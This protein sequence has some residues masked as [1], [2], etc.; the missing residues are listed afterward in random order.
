ML[1]V[2]PEAISSNFPIFVHMDC[3]FKCNDDEFPILILG[4]TD[5]CQKFHPLSTSIISHQTEDMYEELMN[6]F[7]RLTPHVL[8]GVTFT[9]VYGMIDCGA[10]KRY[11]L[12]LCL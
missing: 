11:H 9:P 1:S 12:L 4:T 2:I 5:S 8:T 3:T 10:A 6:N 7:N